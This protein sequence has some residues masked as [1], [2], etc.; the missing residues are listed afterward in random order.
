MRV[1]LMYSDRCNFQCRHCMVDSKIEN[2]IVASDSV[3]QRFLEIVD[4]NRPEQVCILGGEPLLFLDEMEVL[5]QRIKQYC[6]NVLIYSNGSFLLDDCNRHRVKSLGVQVR[7]SKTDFHKDFWKP[8]LEHIINESNYWKI[9]ALDKSISIF[10]RGRALINNIYKNQTCPC[11]LMTEDY[12]NKYHSNRILVMPDG[13]VNIW[14]PC[15]ALELANVFED[16]IITHDLL[17]DRECQLRDYLKEVNMLHDNM[18]FMCNEVCNRF[19][20]TKK[21]IYRDDELMKEF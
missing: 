20:V 19:K 2:Y 3:V 1:G 9:E 21:G 16:D 4:K 18:L 11:S 12:A 14:C 7:I 17:I 13:S 10:P 6:D 15:M 5:V 8:D